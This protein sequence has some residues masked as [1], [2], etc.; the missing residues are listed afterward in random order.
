MQ[1]CFLIWIYFPVSSAWGHLHQIGQNWLSIALGDTNNH[2]LRIWELCFLFSLFVGFTF[3]HVLPPALSLCLRPF[4]SLISESKGINLSHRFSSGHT[5]ALSH[6]F[7]QDLHTTCSLKVKC[8]VTEAF[9]LEHGAL[10][11]SDG[12]SSQ[13]EIICV[14]SFTADWLM[15]RLCGDK[16]SV[17]TVIWF[18]VGAFVWHTGGK[19]VQEGDGA[20]LKYPVVQR[21]ALWHNTLLC[22]CPCNLCLITIHSGSRWGHAPLQMINYVEE[23]VMCHNH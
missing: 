8:A 4:P 16:S 9:A 7:T 21:L 18:S 10:F 13:V 20:L 3:S 17:E 2:W 23:F 5:D 19:M 11:F 14:S 1:G 6:L 15:L 12:I 22:Y